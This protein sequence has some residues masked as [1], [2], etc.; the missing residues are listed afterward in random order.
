VTPPSGDAE[1]GGPRPSSPPRVVVL[2]DVMCD[3]VACHDGPIAVGSDTPASVV[4]R[5]GG[6]GATVAAWLA[7]AGVPVALIGRAGCDAAA[8]IA[9]RGLE[10]VDVRVARDA[11]RPTGTCVVLVAPD[12]ERTMLPDPGANDALAPEDLPADL[13]AGPEVLHVAG[14]MLLRP[15]SRRA[16]LAA[17]DRARRAG[18]RISLDPSSAA[19]LRADPGFLARARPVDL[20]LPNE[21]EH[22]ALGPLDGVSEVVVTRGAAGASWTGGG[23]SHR[24]AARPLDRVRDTT[25]AGDAFAAGFLSAWPGPPEVALDAGVRLAAEAIAL[26][27]E[28]PMIDRSVKGAEHA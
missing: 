2:G 14:Y 12:G 5:P 23:R 24:I 21:L 28:R 10:R 9:L 18:M 3:V 13:F 1:G 22:A 27:G 25:G 17:L 4:M 20:L 8:E 15:G 11:E 16:A 26:H 19:P 6:S 7:H